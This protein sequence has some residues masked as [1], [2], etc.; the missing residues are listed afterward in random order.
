M[1]KKSKDFE[2]AVRDS[3]G[4]FVKGGSDKSWRYETP[5]KEPGPGDAKQVH[6]LTAAGH[7][8]ASI[9]AKMGISKLAFQRWLKDHQE[10]RAAYEAG[11]AVE[12][13]EILSELRKI[14]K[15]GNATPG[16]FL[17]K[18]RHGYREGE[19]QI[20]DNRVQISVQL[21]ASLS[22]EQYKQVIDVTK[23]QKLPEGNN[24]E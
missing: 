7:G 17:L 6:R 24:N 14:L 13:Q 23:K 22:P 11:L 10:I 20:E 3:K 8:H 18:A 2:P 12:E 1:A 9:A 5:K 21:P 15:K 19:S 4:R 16:I